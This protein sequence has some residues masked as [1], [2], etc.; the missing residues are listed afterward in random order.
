MYGRCLSSNTAFTNDTRTLT[1]LFTHGKNAPMINIPTSGAP[2][3]PLN[4]K[5]I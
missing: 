3:A 4:V 5:D 2:A 1:Y